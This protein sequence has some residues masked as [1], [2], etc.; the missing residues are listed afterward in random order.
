MKELRTGEGTLVGKFGFT[1]QG[2]LFEYKHK[3]GMAR[4][5]LPLFPR[6]GSPV[7]TIE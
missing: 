7:V 4:V 5:Y 2:F 1:K 6:L 3:K